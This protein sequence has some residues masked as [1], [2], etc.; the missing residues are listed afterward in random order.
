MG[1]TESVG[2]LEVVEVVVVTGAEALAEAADGETGSAV[3]P[4]D[5]QCGW[6]STARLPGQTTA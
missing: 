2:A 3:T 5:G 6:T 1:V 4:A